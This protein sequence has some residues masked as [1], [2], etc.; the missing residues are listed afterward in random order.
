[1]PEYTIYKIQVGEQIYIGSTKD[2][3]N[4]KYQHKCQTKK[5]NPLIIYQAIREAGGWQKN[6]MVPIELYECET[7]TEACIREQHWLREY[8][9]TLNMRQA[10]T[11]AE[12]KR[13]SWNNYQ[14]EYAK[15]R[16]HRLKAAHLDLGKID[17]CCAPAQHNHLVEGANALPATDLNAQ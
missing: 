4:R 3:K 8:N 14:R 13:T 17:V 9:A 12:E 11:T 10:Y 6:M 5:E 15:K 7:P 16:Y 2:F 1:M